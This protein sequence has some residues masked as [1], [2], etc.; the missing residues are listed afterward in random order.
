M[1]LG[2]R[3][4][5]CDFVLVHFIYKIY[6]YLIFTFLSFLNSF[7]FVFSALT[8]FLNVRAVQLCSW[9]AKFHRVYSSRL[10]LTHLPVI[11]AFY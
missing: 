1:S 5:P 11:F 7:L 8:F 2:Q 3:S 9:R 6:I 4:L 10:A